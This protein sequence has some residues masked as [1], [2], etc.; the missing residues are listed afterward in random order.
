MASDSI[1]KYDSAGGQ[2]M[3]PTSHGYELLNKTLF[4]HSLYKA[5]SSSYFFFNSIYFHQYCSSSRLPNFLFPSLHTVGPLFN[6]QGRQLAL[7]QTHP[8]TK[9]KLRIVVVRAA[10]RGS[11]QWD[12]GCL[13]LALI[14]DRQTHQ[15][16]EAPVGTKKT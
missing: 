9:G 5:C 2:E 11:A 6:S 15:A 7:H 8:R 3:T 12:S 1:L 4:Y 10:T 14:T 13:W 16:L